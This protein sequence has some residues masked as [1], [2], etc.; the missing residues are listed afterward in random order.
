MIKYEMPNIRIFIRGL[1]KS[2]KCMVNCSL[3]RNSNK[4]A[5]IAERKGALSS[6]KTSFIYSGEPMMDMRKKT[7]NAIGYV[8]LNE[9]A[10]PSIPAHLAPI[11]YPRIK[12][13]VL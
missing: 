10:T 8:M 1:S 11:K 13:G 6:L 5:K 2:G 9:I 3:Q 7:I 12:T 4:L